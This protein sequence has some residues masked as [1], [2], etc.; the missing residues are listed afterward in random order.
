[1][2]RLGAFFFITL[3]NFC[4]E[5]CVVAVCKQP[6]DIIRYSGGAR[7]SRTADLLNAIHSCLLQYQWVI[8]DFIR[9]LYN[10]QQREYQE[11][12]C[13]VHRSFRNKDLSR[14]IN[15]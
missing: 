4:F 13:R 5:K 3:Y 2:R 8:D 7:R 9:R 14:R 1:M 10:F 6:P 11:D 15:I 12:R